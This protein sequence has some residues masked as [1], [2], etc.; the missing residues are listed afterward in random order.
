MDRQADGEIDRQ[1]DWRTWLRTYERTDRQADGEIDRQTD[2]RT[3]ARVY[4]QTLGQTEK[5]TV[6]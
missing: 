5:Q 2:R 6:R 4:T 1:A 3:G